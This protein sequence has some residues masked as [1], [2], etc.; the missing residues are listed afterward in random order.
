MRSV[1]R[2]YGGGGLG[3][4]WLR[5]GGGLCLL[6]RMGLKSWGRKGSV[7]GGE[8]GEMGEWFE[9]CLEDQERD[10]VRVLGKRI[11]WLDYVQGIVLGYVL[12]ID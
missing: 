6:G 8:M 4:V 1:A 11:G 5:W 2:C 3:S 9:H 12:L 7:V 10:S